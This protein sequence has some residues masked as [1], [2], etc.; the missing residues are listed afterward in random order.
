MRR[1]Y[2]VPSP[3]ILIKR[4]NMNSFTQ[5]QRVKALFWLSLFHLLVIISSNYL[6][7]LPIS[8][9]GFHTTGR[10]Q[11]PVYFPCDGFNRAY[12]WRTAGAADYFCGDDPGTVCLLRHLLAVLHGKLAGLRSA[13]ALQPVRRAYC[14]RQLYGLRPGRSSMSTCL[15]ACVKTI[16]GGW[17]QRPPRCSVT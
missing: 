15:T 8:I 14:H 4:Y 17:R 9:F 7:Q 10:V 5:S 11:F 16:A 2:W 3:Q 6:V 13:D 1:L 12:F